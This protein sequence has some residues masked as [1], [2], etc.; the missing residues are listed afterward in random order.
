MEVY[1]AMVENLDHNIGRLLDALRA[2]GQLE[3]TLV[4]FFSD[5]GPEGN[6]INKFAKVQNW[7]EGRLDLGYERVGRRGSYAWLG[8]GWASASVA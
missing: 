2:S 8:P 3:N 7:P 4:L 1:A 6:A 5:N